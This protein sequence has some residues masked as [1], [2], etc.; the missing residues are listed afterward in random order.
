MQSA[1]RTAFTGYERVIRALAGLSMAAIVVIMVVQVIARYAFSSLIWA[2]ELCRYI[3]IW[4]TFLFIG[5][6]YH[7]GEL[8]VLDLFSTRVSPRVYIALRILTAIPIAVF[9]GFIIRAGIANALRF[10]EQMIPAL[11]FIG[12]SLTGEELRVPIFWVYVAVPVGCGVLLAHFLGRLAYDA[13]CVAT[14][15]PVTPPSNAETMT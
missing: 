4:Q 8:V 11:N 7:Q 12:M 9:L 6:A 3:L 5:Y 14:G 15:R 13:W 10:S 2:E 1:F